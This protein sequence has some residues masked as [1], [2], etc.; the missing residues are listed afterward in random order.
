MRYFRFIAPV[1]IRKSRFIVNERALAVWMNVWHRFNK[2]RAGAGVRWATIYWRNGDLSGGKSTRVNSAG[3][4]AEDPTDDTVADEASE[5]TDDA[6]G[7]NALLE[8][9]R[10]HPRL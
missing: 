7:S 4:E 3:G 6:S 1:H 5:L 8:D 10:K 2:R 9:Q